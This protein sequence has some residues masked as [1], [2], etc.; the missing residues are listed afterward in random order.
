MEIV[1]RNRREG[2]KGLR[3]KRGMFHSYSGRRTDKKYIVST[4]GSWCLFVIRGR[5]R[6][7]QIDWENKEGKVCVCVSSSRKEGEK[8]K[9]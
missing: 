7:E 1:S 5:D 2:L 4:C 6:E 8:K 3:V 9:S